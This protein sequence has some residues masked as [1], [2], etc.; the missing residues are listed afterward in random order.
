MALCCANAASAFARF[1]SGDEP[2]DLL[3]QKVAYVM[4]NLLGCAL[5]AYKLRNMGLLP[6]T[7]SDWLEFQH[8]SQVSYMF[9]CGMIQTDLVELCA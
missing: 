8:E 3:W 6:T 2:V 5:A 9:P 7:S 4:L 1:E